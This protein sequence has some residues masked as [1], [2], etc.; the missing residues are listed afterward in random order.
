MAESASVTIPNKPPLVS[1]SNP[2]S[3]SVVSLGGLVVMQGAATD[4]E[5][6][7]IADGLLT[8]ASDRQGALGAGPSIPTNTLQ[9]GW[10]NI[11]LSVTDSNGASSSQTT[12]VFIGQQIFTPIVTKQ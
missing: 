9:F 7:H 4:L 11:T 8:W 6:G 1:I 10:H 2:I 12:R 3:G 5:D